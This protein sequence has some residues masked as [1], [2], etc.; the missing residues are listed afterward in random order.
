MRSPSSEEKE[1]FLLNDYGDLTFFF[2]NTK[3][4]NEP[5]YIAATKTNINGSFSMKVEYLAE[6]IFQGIMKEINKEESRFDDL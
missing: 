1:K 5:K 2:E 3:N 6:V 4:P